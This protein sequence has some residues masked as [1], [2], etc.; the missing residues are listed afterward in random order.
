MLNAIEY[1][2]KVGVG[3]TGPEFFRANDDKI[4]VVKRA[5]NR[6]GKTVLI[7]EFLAAQLG[8]KIGLIFPPSDI[9]TL[10]KFLLEDF[11]PPSKHF[12]S[13]YI[14][15]CQYTTSENILRADN[16]HEMAGIILFDHIFHNVDRTNNRK[17]ILLCEQDHCTTI[18]AIDN[19]HLFK[20]GRWSISALERLAPQ[21]KVYPNYL[22]GVLLKKYLV[23][24]DFTPYLDRIKALSSNDIL[25]I[26]NEIPEE[27]L[28]SLELK[29]ALI[30]F[31]S[32]RCH[33]VDKIYKELLKKI[34][35]KGNDCS[36]E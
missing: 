24:E 19:S 13:Q 23:P 5:N 16:L 11:S 14:A 6:V 12:A 18:Y 8:R 17:N 29:T 7:S 36:I 35:S 21:I 28:E 2:G 22:Y 15:K 34:P 33:I 10:E 9:I 30:Q 25:E 20:T 3:V 27:W 32:Y 4:Y 1:L 31:I 26:V